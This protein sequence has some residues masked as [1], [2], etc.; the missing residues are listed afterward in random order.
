MTEVLKN[1]N[2]RDCNWHFHRLV[3]ILLFL[4]YCISTGMFTWSLFVNHNHRKQH[5]C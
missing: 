2:L 4:Q 5:G 3:T 1:G